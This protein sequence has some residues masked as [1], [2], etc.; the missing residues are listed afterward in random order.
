MNISDYNNAINGINDSLTRLREQI[1]SITVPDYSN[2]ISPIN[3]S[4]ASLQEQ[5]NN[6]IKPMK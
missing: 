6:L 5:L 2:E 3:D 4:R 1:D